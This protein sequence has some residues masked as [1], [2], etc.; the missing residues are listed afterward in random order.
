LKK[1]K[2]P[3]RNSSNLFL[4]NIINAKDDYA[5]TKFFE[6]FNKVHSYYI[7]NENEK[8]TPKEDQLLN[9][10]VSEV[11]LN[12]SNAPHFEICVMADF[13]DGEL[14]NQNKGQI[15]CSHTSETLGDDLVRLIEGEST[16]NL[17]W[18]LQKE[19][20]IFSVVNS[21]T[22]TATP[23]N[24]RV[25]KVGRVLEHEAEIKKMD[26][27]E[28]YSW[29]SLDVINDNAIESALEK[30]NRFTVPKVW[31]KDEILDFWKIQ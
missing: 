14:N 9:V 25:E 2:K 5:V 11:N 24:K 15:F 8:L 16:S 13:F 1:F 22:K 26:N 29:L 27:S 19:R 30:V 23:S 12:D 4:Q 7:E 6:F 10:G 21:V 20:K 31:T 18:S 17:L 28:L 3:V